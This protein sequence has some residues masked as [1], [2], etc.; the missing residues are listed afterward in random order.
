MISPTPIKR[1]LAALL[2]GGATAF[3][4]AAP[5]AKPRADAS[6]S[7]VAHDGVFREIDLRGYGTV[8]GVKTDLRGGVSQLSIRC[9][10]P[11]KAKLLQAK[12]LSDL[13]LLPKVSESKITLGRTGQTATARQIEGQGSIVAVRRGSEVRILSAAE[14]AALAA[15]LAGPEWAGWEFATDTEVPMYLDRW[16]R[17]GFRAYHRT[18]ENPPKDYKPAQAKGGYDFL[19]EFQFAEEMDRTGLVVFTGPNAMDTAGG[20]NRDVWWDWIVPQTEARG[21]PLGLNLKVA[22]GIEATWLTNRYREQMMEPMPQFGG[23][24][25][26]IGTP[27]YGG[28]GT[29][30]WAAKEANQI[31]FDMAET[32]LRRFKDQPNLTTVLE[33][34]GELKNVAHS[35]FVEYGSVA[36]ASYR[37]YLKTR[38]DD[39]RALNA[40]WGT[41]HASWDEVRV[42]EIASFAGW[43]EDAVDLT[44]EWK[45]AYEDL[46]PNLDT[47]GERLLFFTDTNW[48]RA[49][50]SL[51]APQE[52]FSSRFD[53]SGWA[54]LQAPGDERSLV[55]PSR[56]GVMRRHFSV[57]RDWLAKHPQV[58]LYVWSM[59]LTSNDQF[60]AVLNDKV[61]DEST[62][63]HMTPHWTAVEVSQHLKP[64]GNV[65]ALRLPKGKLSYRVYLSGEEPHGYPFFEKG[66]NAQ[67]YDFAMWHRW[68]RKESV[69]RGLETIRKTH[70][71][72]QVVQMAPDAY[73]DDINDLA[74]RYGSNFHNTGYMAAFW[75]DYLPSLMRGRNLPMSVEPGGPARDG[76]HFKTFQGLWM[77]EGVQG[78]DYFIHIGSLMWNA[79]IRQ[80]LKQDLPLF[81]LIGKYHAPKAEVAAF[82]STENI[83]LNGCPGFS[84]PTRP[85]APATGAGTSAPTCA[86]TTP[87]TAS[88]RPPSPTATPRPTAS[89]STPT[90]PS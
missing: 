38:Y 76:K 27:F 67:W 68:M 74:G 71:N 19:S 23:S 24:F 36:D 84:I 79:E 37:K 9:E 14:S 7:A 34:H 32:M 83:R 44:G 81:R 75:A 22:E 15:A 50:P 17:W 53:D 48:T 87:A 18:W 72:H 43:G 56:P 63:R 65:L 80:H 20:L 3:A 21:L 85:W 46:P 42:Q 28:R 86:T 61:V 29:A 12:Y 88:A 78:I 33:P 2:L 73:A 45:L 57:S 89:S 47:Q 40:A 39:L 4:Q 51:G 30:S 31:Q 16:D 60:K 58:W 13:S 64:E 1:V 35:I 90:A 82:Y 77:T 11:E 10:S 54:S 49:I 25:F 66:R 41:A 59:N 52:W 69:R 6:T 70:P 55:I 26:R 5:D 62:V 8:S